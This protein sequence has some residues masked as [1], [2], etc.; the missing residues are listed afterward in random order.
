MPYRRLPRTDQ[1]RLRSL[2]MAVENSVQGGVYTNILT[3]NTHYKAKNLLQSL[4]R[5]VEIYKRCQREQ[6]TK[7][8]NVKY[9]TALKN[10]RMYVS[11]FI[12]VLSMSVQRGE[13][14]RS[15]RAYYGLDTDDDTVP[16]LNTETAVLEW[17]AKIME[18]ERRRQAEGGIPVY[19]PTMGRVS[20][21]Y[22]MFKDMYERQQELQMRTQKSLTDIAMLRPEVDAIIL[23]VWN[24]VEA[25]FA[26]YPAEARLKR[27]A[28][29]GVIYYTRADR[30]R[31]EE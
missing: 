15:K 16:N 3:H 6:S 22:D 12:Q 1:A 23:E 28:E 26:A 31:K 9:E 25:A 17:G 8:G 11:H 2:K 29:Y 19:N 21:V 5:E 27:C 18:G 20:V 4:S 7:R 10:A 14:A 30:K 24:E 13:I